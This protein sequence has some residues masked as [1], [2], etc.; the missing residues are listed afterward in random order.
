MWKSLEDSKSAA[1]DADDGITPL[2]QCQQGC[3]TMAHRCSN[4][5]SECKE[6]TARCLETWCPGDNKSLLK[7]SQPECQG[8]RRCCSS[9]G[10][11][12]NV[13]GEIREIHCTAVLMQ[14]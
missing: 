7:L 4:F 12:T 2:P 1:D 11:D 3:Y 8:P 10:L 14:P 9:P 6:F 13:L 5:R